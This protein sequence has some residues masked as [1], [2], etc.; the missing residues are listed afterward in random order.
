MVMN[1]EK[2]CAPRSLFRKDLGLSGA[3]EAE[4]DMRMALPWNQDRRQAQW[5]LTARRW[6]RTSEVNPVT[7]Q[8][9]VSMPTGP[10]SQQTKDQ[11]CSPTAQAHQAR[12]PQPAAQAWQ[13]GLRRHSKGQGPWQL[14][15][16]ATHANRVLDVVLIPTVASKATLKRVSQ[17]AW[18]THTP[19][20]PRPRCRH[21]S[22]DTGS[23]PPLRTA[24]L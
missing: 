1:K 13:A 8:I 9:D 19:L 12:R 6:C 15:T 3:P 22:S 2:T 16:K 7:T 23:S 24:T 11:P 21:M 10:G 17:E 4:T 18:P 14:S 20:S 5:H